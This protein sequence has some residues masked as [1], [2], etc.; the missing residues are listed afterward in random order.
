MIILGSLLFAATLAFSPAPSPAPP[1]APALDYEAGVTH[2]TLTNNYPNWDSQYL[3]ITK[4]TAERQTF[5]AQFETVSRFNKPDDQFTLGAYFPLSPQWQVIA[6]GS[7]SNK[8]TILPSSSV[9]AGIQYN[10]GGNWFEGLAA[11]TTQYDTASVNSGIFS[12]EHYWSRYRVYYSL[13]AARLAGTGTDV[14]QAIEFDTYYGKSENSSVG[15]GYVT[16]RE[17]ENVGLPALLTSNV[18][19]WNIVGRHWMDDHWAIVY[20]LGSFSQGNSYTRAGGHLGIDY[21]F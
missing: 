11:R 8:H 2:E 20:G 21:R 6:E 15:I 16:G 18:D 5:Y 12:L 19:G 17:V 1:P 3:R 14:E 4:K 10:S 7:A 9:M 13:T